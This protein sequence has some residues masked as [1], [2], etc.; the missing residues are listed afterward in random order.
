LVPFLAKIYSVLIILVGLFFVIKNRNTNNETLF[1]CAYVVGSEVFLRM[2]GG[3]LLYELS[4]YSII[5]FSVLGMVYNGFSKNALPYWLFIILLLPGVLIATETLNLTT[6]IR[7]TIAFNIV[8]PVCLG[9]SSLYTYQRKI[10][11]SQVNDLLLTMGLPII[12]TTSYLIFFTP[13]IKSIITD[14]SSNFDASG[15]F[16]PNQVA[17]ALGL[18][19]FIFFSRILLASPNK[20]LLLINI[21]IAFNISYRGLVTFSRGGM[22]TGF[23][24]IVILLLFLYKKTKYNGKVKLNYI[25]VLIVIAMFA[26]WAYTSNQTSGLIEK[27]YANEDALGR[28]KQSVL[29]GREEI[30]ANEMESFFEHPLFGI[31]VAK[32][33]E[34]RLAATG[35]ITPSHNEITRMIGE[36]GALGIMALLL[37]IFTPII[38]YLDNEQNIYS[39]C[40]LAFWL[41]TINHAAMRI[42]APAFVYSLALLKVKFNEEP[43]IHRK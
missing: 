22:I 42:A 15:G 25:L 20:F 17:T 33:M 31:G 27:R 13:D 34:L 37:L 26:T 8:G 3:N 14:T 41:L 30:S 9:I 38:L 29:T 2:T 36:H 1:V 28:K 10:S 5:F 6:D 43:I 35:A 16:G 19:M 12:S 21:V 4:K 23:V 11:F 7:K 40:F 39:F 32:G 24:M 18:G